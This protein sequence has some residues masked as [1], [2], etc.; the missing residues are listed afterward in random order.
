MVMVR[1]SKV[2]REHFQKIM[3]ELFS[4]S[5]QLFKL[6]GVIFKSHCN[7]FT[8]IKIKTGLT[9]LDQGATFKV[10]SAF[11]R[12]FLSSMTLFDHDFDIFTCFLNIS[13][14]LL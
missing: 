9:F 2:N 8:K 1:F 10:T 12:A 14:S 5:R 13:V 7:T 3:A 11:R 4:R 6:V